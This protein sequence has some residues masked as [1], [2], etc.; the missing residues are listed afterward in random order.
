M[1]YKK[2]IH[3]SLNKGFTL[4]ELMVVI[5]IIAILAAIVLTFLRSA[6]SN[7]IDSKIKEQL[8]NMRAQA[9][10]WKGNPTLVSVG[11][12]SSTIVCASGGDL[13]TDLVSNSSLCVFSSTLPSGT[14]YA[15]GSD[16]TLPS[17]G[18]KWY[19][20]AS[21]TSGSFCSDYRGIAKTSSN[22]LGV[23]VYDSVNY[24]CK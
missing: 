22:S 17:V 12:A 8:S 4:I 5:G 20:S 18:G 6:N 10:L 3:F 7:A 21:L 16:A 24:I 1:K 15:Y 19:F 13:F 9:Q 2:N 23:S 11:P 14:S